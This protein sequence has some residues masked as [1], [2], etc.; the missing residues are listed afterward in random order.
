MVCG[1]LNSDQLP[2]IRIWRT[3]MFS[4]G[5]HRMPVPGSSPHRRCQRGRTPIVGNYLQPNAG[6]FVVTRTRVALIFLGVLLVTSA[7]NAGAALPSLKGETYDDARAKMI[8][9]GYRPVRFVR[10]EDGCLLDKSCNRYPELL[11]CWPTD[12]AHCQF[13]FVKRARLEYVVVTTRG[14][15]TR[16]VYSVAT[17]SRR[18]RMSWPILARH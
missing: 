11:S 8:R 3:P 1:G 13:V 18:E 16:R 5:D 10:T 9:L 2:P 14:K 7:A 12:P 6:E 4:T 17:A 15:K